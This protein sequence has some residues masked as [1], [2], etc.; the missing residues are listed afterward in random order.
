L[1]E[2]V[3]S[4]EQRTAV[5]PIISQQQ[6]A[7]VIGFAEAGKS[8]ML[9]AARNAWEA[10]GYLVY[11]AAFADKAAEG[12]T[13]FLGIVASTLTSWEYSWIWGKGGL[14]R[15]DILVID[16]AGMVGSRQLARIVSEV[17]ARGAKLVLVG[18][19]DK[20]QA[21][22]AGSNFRAIAERIGSV[23]LTDIRRQ[24]QDWQSGVGGV[25]HPSHG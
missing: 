1:N 7:A 3:L 18:D 24:K 22:G 23:E 20:L 10:Q 8:T 5:R 25:C 15:G 2:S 21:S 12:F 9:A 13:G 11:G 4:D 6:I 14:Q 17:E 16:E 19:N